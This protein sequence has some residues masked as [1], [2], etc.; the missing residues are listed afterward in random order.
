MTRPEWL[1]DVAYWPKA[2]LLECRLLGRYRGKSGHQPAIAE[3]SRSSAAHN[4]R[5]R[6]GLGQSTRA[7]NCTDFVPVSQVP[8][9]RID[10]SVGLGGERARAHN[11]MKLER[12]ISS[13]CGSDQD[14]G[15]A[16]SRARNS[17]LERNHWGQRVRVEGKVDERRRPC[18]GDEAARPSPDKT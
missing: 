16:R 8:K 14:V 5:L 6:A 2:D 7:I 13:I 4:E 11:R 10:C 1:I 3:Q 9:P 12:E 15:D 18:L 17:A